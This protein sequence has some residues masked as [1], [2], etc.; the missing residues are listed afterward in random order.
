M[1]GAIFACARSLVAS[2]SRFD[3]AQLKP[4]EQ[5]I[6]RDSNA[7]PDAAYTRDFA[8]GYGGIR[9]LAID[10]HQIG[11]FLDGQYGWQRNCQLPPWSTDAGLPMPQ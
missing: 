10:A 1:S 7:A 6:A 3:L 11:N 4:A 2:L 5:D 8:A 9:G